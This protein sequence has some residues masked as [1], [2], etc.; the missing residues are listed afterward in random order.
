MPDEPGLL[1]HHIEQLT[2]GSGISLQVIMARGY[3]S[4]EAPDGYPELKRLGFSRPQATNLPGLL[5]PLWTT[6]GRN[7]LVVYRPDNPRLDR[8]GHVIKYE[9][10]KGAG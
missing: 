5:L 4:I 9:I 10:P 6:D 3:R 8:Q 2:Q 1:P 7:G